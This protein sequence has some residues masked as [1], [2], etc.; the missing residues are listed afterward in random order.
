[1]GGVAERK[2]VYRRPQW[3]D[4]SGALQSS[5]SPQ[6]PKS[7]HVPSP[8][9]WT[10]RGRQRRQTNGTAFRPRP[11]V[12]RAEAARTG[13]QD[14]EDGIG[15]GPEEWFGVSRQEL[16]RAATRA[17]FSLSWSGGRAGR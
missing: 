10:S 2:P 12:S 14:L 16:K 6:G 17:R 1:M 11:L 13:L 9:V 8:D 3:R 4:K 7:Y 15:E 5:T